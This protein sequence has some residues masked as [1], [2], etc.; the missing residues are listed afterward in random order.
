MPNKTEWKLEYGF[1]ELPDRR[2]V[3]PIGR[4]FILGKYLTVEKSGRY[5]RALQDK[6]D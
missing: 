3:K 2:E 5:I 6:N 1:K 4:L